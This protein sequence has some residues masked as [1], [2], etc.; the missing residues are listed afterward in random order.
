M[1]VKAARGRSDLTVYLGGFSKGMIV[2]LGQNLFSK[3]RPITYPD[4]KRV[5]CFVEDS[6][7]AI[8]FTYWW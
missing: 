3:M 6:L 1:N 5:N 7:C 2:I 4:A 8:T